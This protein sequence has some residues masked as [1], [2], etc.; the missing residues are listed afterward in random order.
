ML[1]LT[2]PARF[3]RRVLS[4][5][6]AATI[7]AR[8]AAGESGAAIA[9]SLNVHRNTVYSVKSGQSWSC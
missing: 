6:L 5:A 3:W 7:R 2:L 4:A 8:L 1:A 9:R